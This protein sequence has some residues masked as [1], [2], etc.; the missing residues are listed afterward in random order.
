MSGGPQGKSLGSEFGFLRSH[1]GV[2]QGRQRDGAVI[3]GQNDEE[4]AKWRSLSKV[5]VAGESG[6]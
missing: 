2:D 6:R 4:T 5:R 3:R 1:Q